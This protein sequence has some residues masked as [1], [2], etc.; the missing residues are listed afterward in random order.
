MAEAICEHYGEVKRVLSVCNV[1]NSL[2]VEESSEEKA[3][4]RRGVMYGA[5]G[6]LR[7]LRCSKGLQSAIGILLLCL[8]WTAD[9][10]SNYPSY[11]EM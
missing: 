5:L 4:S 11:V 2:S 7:L 9:I 6:A 10:V 1:N 3:L 8:V